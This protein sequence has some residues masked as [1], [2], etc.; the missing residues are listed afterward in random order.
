M[1]D[2]ILEIEMKKVQQYGYDVKSYYRSL[3]EFK[4]NE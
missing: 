4:N 1:V 3:E 2:L